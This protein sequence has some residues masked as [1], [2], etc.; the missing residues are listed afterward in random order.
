MVPRARGYDRF[1]PY[2]RRWNGWPGEGSRPVWAGR[3]AAGSLGGC[4]SCPLSARHVFKKS[5]ERETSSLA[6]LNL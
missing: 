3:R 5:P 2:R 6:C 1:G 4:V